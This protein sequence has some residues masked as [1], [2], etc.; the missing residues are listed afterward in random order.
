MELLGIVQ[1]A[2]TQ[3]QGSFQN[4]A[5]RIA[6]APADPQPPSDSVSLSDD[7]VSMASARN[8]IDANV[9]VAQTAN[10][11]TRQTLSLLA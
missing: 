1:Q 3:A 7:M 11:M 9:G 5:L 4:V 8:Q 2:L 6:R 10:E